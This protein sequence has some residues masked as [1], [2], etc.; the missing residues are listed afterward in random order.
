MA[1]SRNGSSGSLANDCETVRNIPMPTG[2]ATSASHRPCTSI[3]ARMSPLFSFLAKC[4]MNEP[5]TRE[6]RPVS[7]A[8]RTNVAV[9]ARGRK[10]P[11][12]AGVTNSMT[13]ATSSRVLLTIH[14]RLGSSSYFCP[15]SDPAARVARDPMPSLRTHFVAAVRGSAPG[16]EPIPRATNSDCAVM[17]SRMFRNMSDPRCHR[18]N[19]A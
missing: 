4:C 10:R 11:G 12:A 6:P 3:L 2:S 1:T 14:H 13:R 9:A 5:F 8:D 19:G 16:V 7:A 15:P 18:M 17:T